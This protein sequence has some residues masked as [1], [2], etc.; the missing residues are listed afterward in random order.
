MFSVL[1][2]RNQRTSGTEVRGTSDKYESPHRSM[3]SETPPRDETV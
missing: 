2:T 1:E 3:S